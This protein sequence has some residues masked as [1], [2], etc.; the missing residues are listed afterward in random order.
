M[1][2]AF[3]PTKNIGRKGRRRTNE[4]SHSNSLIFPLKIG[5]RAEKG[6]PPLL[7]RIL[8]RENPL[9]GSDGMRNEY[10]IR[11]EVTAIF[12]K[13][14]DGSRLETLIDTVDLPRVME[15]P[16][17]WCAK[18]DKCTK[19]FYVFGYI[20]QSRKDRIHH[21]LHNWIMNPGKDEIVDHIFHDTLDNRRLRLRL[22]PKKA[23]QQNYKGVRIDSQSGVRGVVWHKANKKWIAR[24]DV[25][26]KPHYLGSF[27]TLDEAKRVVER[28][29]AQNMPYSLD[30]L[31]YNMQEA[32][33]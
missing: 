6:L 28:E 16:N 22:I 19:G 5:R 24:Y 33:L 15:F 26:R 11:G 9:K 27:K 8:F 17:T 20:N 25:D 10:E 31:E 1:R 29:R 14:K 12:L 7:G 23:N 18:W 32:A 3:T 2:T 21:R 30:A 4:N 13:R